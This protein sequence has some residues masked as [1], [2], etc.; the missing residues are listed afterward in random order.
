MQ[1][2]VT[3]TGTGIAPDVLE[4]VMEPFFTTKELGKGSG[5]G[6]SMV[7]GFAKQS[8]GAFRIRSELGKGTTAELWLPR[9]PEGAQGASTPAKEEPRRKSTRKLRILLVDDHA[10]VRS[11]TAAVLEDLGHSVVEAANGAEAMKGPAG[12]RLQLRRD[13]QRLCDAAFV[14]HRLPARRPKAMRE[15]AGPDHHRLCRGGRH[16]RPARRRRDLLKPFTAN[17]LESMLWQIC[18]AQTAAAAE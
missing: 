11:T 10:E 4:K 13:D 17:K 8:N 16:Q 14:R 2:C 5:L 1:L 7:Y 15:R 12:R 18:D 6:L 3:D 9:A